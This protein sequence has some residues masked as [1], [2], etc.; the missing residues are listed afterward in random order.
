MF[1][2]SIENNRRCLMELGNVVGQNV[3]LL[4]VSETKLSFARS[5]SCE[6]SKAS[7]AFRAIVTC[8]EGSET[9]QNRT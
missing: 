3:W 5:P 2:L 1:D 9:K 8:F 6:P 7:K 4:K